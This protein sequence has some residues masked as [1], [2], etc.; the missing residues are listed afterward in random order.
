MHR[1]SIID[2]ARFSQAQRQFR[3]F[4]GR[5]HRLDLRVTRRPHRAPLHGDPSARRFTIRISVLHVAELL[6]GF[7]FGLAAGAWVDRL[8]RK[9]IMIATDLG[10]ALL[11]ATIALAAFLG[12]LGLGQLFVIAALV[13]ILSD[14]FD[15][16]FQSFPLC[17][18]RTTNWSRPTASSA[19]RYP[20][21]RRAPSAPPGG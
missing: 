3:P 15:I 12:W 14:F 19:P 21:P 13:S 7:L 1:S 17:S 11:I 20:W 5:R 18:S 16:A 9:P 4:V 6:P 8:P 2:A 10:C